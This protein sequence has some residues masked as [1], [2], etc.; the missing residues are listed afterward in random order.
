MAPENGNYRG[1]VCYVKHNSVIQCGHC[2]VLLPIVVNIWNG[3]PNYLLAP[4]SIFFK[5]GAMYAHRR[6][7]KREAFCLHDNGKAFA[8]IIV[9]LIPLTDPWIYDPLLTLYDTG[10]PSCL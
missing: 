8:V 4:L 9:A 10:I 5:T 1:S 2:F 6:V 7:R 3:L